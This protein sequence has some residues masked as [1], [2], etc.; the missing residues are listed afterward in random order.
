MKLMRLAAARTSQELVVAGVARDAE[1]GPGT[2][3]NYLTLLEALRLVILVPA[4][5]TSVTT[6]AKRRPKVV[7]VDT[8]LAAD[9]NGLAVR[10]L[11]HHG[12]A[13]ADSLE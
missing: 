8:G 5:S 9:L 7:V 6:R 12:G 13:Q 3:A 2:A 10:H 11:R 4:W 1:I